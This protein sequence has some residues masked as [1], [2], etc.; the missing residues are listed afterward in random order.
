MRPLSLLIAVAFG[1][2]AIGCADPLEQR[3]GQELQSQFQRGITGQGQLGPEQ[4][5]T[6]DPAAEHSVPLTHP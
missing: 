2:L 6:G 4:H 1:S 3:T 5:D